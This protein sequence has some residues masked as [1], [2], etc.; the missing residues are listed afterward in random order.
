MKKISL[1]LIAALL[2]LVMLPSCKSDRGEI[3]KETT[4]SPKEEIVSETTIIETEPPTEKNVELSS[5]AKEYLDS[6]ISINLGSAG[7]SLR[8]YIAAANLIKLSELEYAPEQ[9][10]L[11]IQNLSTENQGIFAYNWELISETSADKFDHIEKHKEDLEC[12]GV[13]KLDIAKHSKA[14]FTGFNNAVLDIF[15]DMNITPVSTRF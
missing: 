10:K 2:I 8:T 1:S 6:V 12:A 3:E 4:E 13:E 11:Y 9:T 5:E 7:C 14:V 15:K